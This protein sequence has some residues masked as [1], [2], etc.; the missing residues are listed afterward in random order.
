MMDSRSLLGHVRFAVSGGRGPGD[1][2]PFRGEY[3]KK[4]FHMTHNGWADNT[5]KLREWLKEKGRE[6]KT[7]VDS[8]LL[9]CLIEEV[10]I[11]EW[12]K[13]LEELDVGGKLNILVHWSDKNYTDREVIQG[14]SHGDLHYY[15]DG[16]FVIVATEPVAVYGKKVKTKKWT[17]LKSGEI[18]TI[19]NG[20]L[21]VK[22]G[23]D[24]DRFEKKRTVYKV[25]NY[26]DNYWEDSSY[27]DDWD[28]NRNKRG[29][30][31]T[32]VDEIE[33]DVKKMFDDE[34]PET[35]ELY[36]V[37]EDVLWFD[38]GMGVFL[39]KEGEEVDYEDA[40]NMARTWSIGGYGESLKIEKEYICY[41]CGRFIVGDPSIIEYEKCPR[42]KNGW[43][44]QTGGSGGYH[45]RRQRY[46]R[47][48]GNY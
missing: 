34:T 36:E 33:N 47:T 44:E 12:A 29:S 26:S 5:D 38:E 13:V 9:K 19:K 45:S 1:A 23:I 41:N 4:P 48:Y 31:T 37:I 46:V 8:E 6:P 17:H 30:K 32:V 14:Y 20:E 3:K 43:L 16:N 10:G 15:Q 27:S 21:S 42:C 11:E 2:H 39:D 40:L 7:R 25:Y 24:L 18:V 28:Y 35:E 22:K